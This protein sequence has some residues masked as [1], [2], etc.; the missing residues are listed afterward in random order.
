M[1]C[2][3]VCMQESTLPVHKQ[4]DHAHHQMVM[5]MAERGVEEGQGAPT[6]ASWSS[7]SVV[8]KGRFLST[9]IS[10]FSPK[11]SKS[12]GSCPGVTRSQRSAVELN[13]G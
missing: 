9:I 4:F 12:R 7:F 3:C 5:V 6:M 13:E 1:V 10:F 2:V 8:L 11:R